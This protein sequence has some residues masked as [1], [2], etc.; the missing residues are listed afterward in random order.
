M[1]ENDIEMVVEGFVHAAQSAIGAGCDGVEINAGQHSL[2]RQFLSGLTNH[3]SDAWGEDKSLFARTVIS[4]VRA[5]A[6]DAVVGLRLSCDELA[7]WAG[8]TPDMAVELAPQLVAAGI[9]YLVVVRGSIFSVEKTRPDFHEPEGFNAA[10]TARINAVVS[11]PVFLQGSIVS[12]QAANDAIINNICDGVEMTRANIAD[13]DLVAKL[14]TNN[15]AQIRPCIRCNQTCQV[16]DVRNPIVTCVVEPTSGHESTDPNWYSSV[17][18]KSVAI[19][20]AGPAGL[21]AALTAAKRGHRVIVYERRGIAGGVAQFAGPGSSFVTWLFE[22]C[23]LLGVQ[24]NFNCD[25]TS[26]DE[27]DADG[28]IQSTGSVRGVAT[29]TLD[30]TTLP[31]DIIDVMSGAVVLPAEGDVVLHDPIGGPIAIALAE[32]LGARCVLV[33]PDNI[34][35]NELSRSGDLAPANVRLAQNGVRVVRRA[36]VRSV[37]SASHASRNADETHGVEVVI[38]DRFSGETSTLGA[39]AFVDCGFRLPSPP[40]A[41]NKI[42]AAG[43]CVAPRTLLEAVLEGRR[44]VLIL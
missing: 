24:F 5:V 17:T 37:T 34:A 42:I 12:A 2:I 18:P 26:I 38:Q 15:A 6:G 36:L 32:L 1:E 14:R 7:P 35:G 13:P 10:L 20:G 25:I 29:Y 40:L 22:Q 11:I 31:L 8:I 41:N 27:L 4:R 39:A 9:D 44:A 16:R 19:I 43:D 21:E 33:T 23:V 30:N 3:R 28:V